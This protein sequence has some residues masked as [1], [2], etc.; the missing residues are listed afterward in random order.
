M[1]LDES[2][3]NTIVDQ[4]VRRLSPEL[5]RVPETEPGSIPISPTLPHR[6]ARRSTSRASVAAKGERGI[7]DDLEAA[8]RAA[9]E[10]FER[11]S[12]V[13]LEDRG[14]AIEAMREVT[15]RH[16]DELSRLAVEETGLGNVKDKIAKNLLCANKTPG[17]EILHPQAFTGDHGLSLLERAPFGVIGAI[18]PST[19]P[20]ETIINNAIGMVAAGNS[21]IFN[22][23]PSAKKVSARH[24]QL[25]NEAIVS[26]GG[27]ASL[28]TGLA[29]PTI[30]SAQNLMKHREVRLI[31]VTGGPAV[32]RA[33]MSS[34]KRAIA[35]G[36][37]NPPVV[38]DETAHLEAAARDIVDGASLDNNIV[39]IVEKEVFAVAAIADRLKR[40]LAEN[41]AVEV[42]GA[43]VNRLERLVVQEGHPAREWIG[44]DAAKIAE[45]AGIRAPKETRLLIAEVDAT[46]PFVQLE[47]LMPVIGLVRLRD[48]EDC[49][50]A[51]VQAEHGFGHTAVM[52]STN[53]DHLHAMAKVINTSIFVK[54][55]PSY[56]GLGM[57][58]EGY[59]S[60]TIASPTGEGLT[61]ALTFTRERRCTLKDHF[62]IV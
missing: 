40:L 61:T 26:A 57:T 27:P 24:I 53:I 7:F 35:A 17:I 41:G 37:G 28:V 18:T 6:T 3:I 52:H 15:R 21:V 19:N 22:V 10:S 45:A 55:G 44:K 33:A 47:L 59:T 51:A 48:V 11:W 25:L 2:Q 30:E 29:E 13:A 8:A 46:H 9:A 50:A 14:R 32:V 56:A 43:A 34:G 16:A 60:F 49:I 20:T 54:N 42:S 31:V 36:P 4:V 1:I 12:D 23:H 5:Q 38:V 58:G 39:C 62:R